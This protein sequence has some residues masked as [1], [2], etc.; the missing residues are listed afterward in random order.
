MAK[1]ACCR[2]EDL[3]LCDDRGGKLSSYDPY[4][5]LA[6]AICLQAFDD[7][8]AR[9]EDSDS[10]Y[11]KDFLA[12]E[13]T[14]E[15][16]FRSEEY[17]YLSG[18]DDGEKAIEMAKFRGAYQRFR[19]SYNCANC[20]CTPNECVHRSGSSWDKIDSVDMFCPEKY[21]SKVKRKY[22]KRKETV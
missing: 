1:R 14:L 4:R 16:F 22:K 11:R 8:K 9:Y 12:S 2:I 3:C 5:A 20:I 19:R 21:K 13:D 18:H 10:T 7:L 17:K 15:K 6:A